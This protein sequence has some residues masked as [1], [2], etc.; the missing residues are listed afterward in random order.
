MS[1]FNESLVGVI[2]HSTNYV[3]FSVFV[4]QTG[5]IITYYQLE[6]NKILPREGWIEQDPVQ[7]YETV[8]NC[9]EVVANKL[10][11]LDIDLK[12]IKCIGITNERESTVVW[13]KYTG[14]PY[15]NCIVWLD[16]RTNDLVESL[17]DKI[18]GRDINWLKSKTGLPISTYFSAPKLRWLIDNDPEIYKAI[19]EKRL[20]FGTIDTWLLWKL[21]GQHMTDVTNASR[22][23]LMDIE[24]C[25]WDDYLLDFFHLPK[26]IL[27]E[28]KSSSDFYGTLTVSELNGIPVT[29]VISDQSAALVG[30]KCFGLSQTKVTCGTGCHIIQNIGPGPVNGALESVSTDAKKNLLITIAFKLGAQPTYYAIEGSAAIAGAAITWLRDNLEVIK[31]YSDVEN[32]AE[33][34]DNC[35]GVYFV[36][37]FQ[38]LYAPHWDSNATGIILGFT[39]YSRKSHLIRATVESIAFQANDILSLMRSDTNGIKIDGIL[40]YNNVLCQALA[41]LAGVTFM[42][43]NICDTISLGA[44]M[45]AGY[46]LG[47]WDIKPEPDYRC[48]IERPVLSNGVTK[49]VSSMKI[50]MRNENNNNNNEFFGEN[51]A[52]IFVPK[53]TEDMR[54]KKIGMWRSAVERSQKW[55]RIERLEHKQQDYKRLSTLPFIAFALMSFGIHIVSQY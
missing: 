11:Q 40:S 6:V 43:P 10:T 4:S 28:I 34:E 20:L 8:L 29:G 12:Q 46:Q 41:D 26:Y 51:F 42:R 50:A 19:K 5:Q 1:D 16:N 27:P 21:T 38:G 15:Y 33:I 47:I 54:H 14:Q 52:D 35:G 25:N 37:G 22:T 24:S 48:V 2:E 45:M 3:R 44:A 23:L 7:I 17:I 9:I 31:H 55:T 49:S 36:P 53:M 39:Q 13:D 30:Q 32:I 18:P